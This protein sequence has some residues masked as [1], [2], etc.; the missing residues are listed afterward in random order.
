[1]VVLMN[2]KEDISAFQFSKVFKCVGWNFCSRLSIQLFTQTEQPE[3]KENE[4]KK[5]NHTHTD[6]VTLN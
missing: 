5:K 1:M 6:Y 2:E 4:R 3:E